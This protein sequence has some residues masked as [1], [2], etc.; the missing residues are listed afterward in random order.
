MEALA[1]KMVV[2]ALLG[3]DIQ[4]QV[5]ALS[6]A[7]RRLARCAPLLA[8]P[9]GRILENIRLPMIGRLRDAIEMVEDIIGRQI[10]EGRTEGALLGA[11]LRS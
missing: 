9:G 1:M 6:R 11:L 8:A 7:L 2:R 3:T 5:P 4:E 10:D